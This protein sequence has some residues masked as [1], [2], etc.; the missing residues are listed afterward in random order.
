M[1]GTIWAVYVQHALDDNTAKIIEKYRA[2]IEE[3]IPG[4][5]RVQKAVHTRAILRGDTNG[6]I[7]FF[8]ELAWS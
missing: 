7:R 3:E 8:F 1:T 2:R 5:C 4:A 6:A